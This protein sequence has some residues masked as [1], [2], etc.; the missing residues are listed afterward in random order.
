M[1]LESHLILESAS[2][3]TALEMLN[4]LGSNAIL[5]VVNNENRLLGSLT[6]GDLRRGFLKS[7]DFKN[8]LIEFIQ[9]DPKFLR[10][11]ETQKER[12]L[13]YRN[14]GLKIL[15]IVNNCFEVIDILFLNEI[16]DILPVNVFILAG[17][18]GERLL[19]LTKN[20]PKPMLKIGEKPIL[21]HN[22]DRL[23]KY[24]IINFHISINYLSDV[25]TNYFG[26]GESKNIS[27]EYVKEPFPM[28]TLGSVKLVQDFT[29]DIV[30]IMNSDILSNIDF[31]TFY[32][33]FIDKDADISVACIPYNVDIPYAVLEISGDNITGLKEKPSYT[34]YSNAGIYLIKKR[35][36]DNFVNLDY[37]NATDLIE[38]LVD[39]NFKVTYFPIYDYW[40]DIGKMDDFTKAQLDIKHLKL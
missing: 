15:P 40:L 2:V 5:F 36:I 37:Y 11:N 27:I 12:L 28:G 33:D 9:T 21:E 4:R 14:L 20:T 24:G 13:E 16:C 8:S 10:Q 6:D 23:I 29:K 22:I 18:K 35:H 25:I 38:T 39:K 1:S 34:Y 3:K 17:G 32:S 26:N 19:P 7:L 31:S 30:L